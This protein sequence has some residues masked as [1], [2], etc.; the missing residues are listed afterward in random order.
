MPGL[1]A[2]GRLLFAGRALRTFC[3]GWLSLALALLLAA[4]G[5]TAAEIGL[6][7][8]ATLVED[9]LLTMA[10]SAVA[11]R[12]GRRRV[13]IG[14]AVAMALGGAALALAADRALV[15][16]AAVLATVSLSGQ[17]AGPFSPLEQSLLPSAAPAAARTRVFAWYNVFGFVPAGLGALAAG[18]WLGLGARL[19]WGDREAHAAV[20]WV[21]V[22]G[23]VALAAIYA[24]LPATIDRE[25]TAADGA[26]AAAARPWLGLHRS[27]GAVLQLASLQALDSFGGG[28]VVQSLLAYW[29]HLRYGASPEALAPVFFGT[30]VLSAVS[31][32]LAARVAD[33]IGLLNTMVFT[34][35]PS[36]V[37]LML[38]PL[39]PSLPVAAALLFARHLLAQMDVPTRQAYAMALVAPDERAAAA[40]LTVSARALAQALSPALT[41]F[42][43]ARA[44]TGLPFYLAGGLK[45]VYDLT[46]YFRFRRVALPADNR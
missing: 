32:P 18:G 15:I 39:A 28:F 10:L 31:F 25:E 21:Y 43:L 3:F 42:A 33:R 19:G 22:A 11:V 9:A 27:R 46:L 6:V 20:L 26:P 5:L 41:G 23:A 14:S 17:E 2:A 38:V 1:T 37:L 29:F 13:L 44:A 24:R 8:T 7:F 34:H 35:L 30:N 16:V 36:N 12:L 4:R 45:I 40:G